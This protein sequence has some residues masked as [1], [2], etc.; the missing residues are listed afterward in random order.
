MG[1]DLAITP[2]KTSFL[3]GAA[4]SFPEFASRSARDS[5]LLPFSVLVSNRGG[6][7]IASVRIQASVEPADGTTLT[8]NAHTSDGDGVAD[9]SDLKLRVGGKD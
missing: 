7:G 4:P 8:G 1:P 6:V 2:T 3:L 9:F 5:G